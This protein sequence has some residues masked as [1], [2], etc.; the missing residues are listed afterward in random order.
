MSILLTRLLVLS[1]CLVLP[2][3]ADTLSP[4]TNQTLTI[5]FKGAPSGMPVVQAEVAR[6]MEPAGFSIT[7]KDI[8][9]RRAGE[10]YAQLARVDFRGNCDLN[11]DAPS[12]TSKVDGQSLAS[13][14]VSDGQVLP[15][16]VV[17][18]DALRRVMHGTLS[19]AHRALRQNLFGRAAARVLAHELFHMLAQTKTHG[20]RGVSK[21]CFGVADLT[22]EGFNFDSETVAQM[23]PPQPQQLSTWFEEA[24]PADFA[25]R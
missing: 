19:N 8:S 20:A 16:A 14:A 12:T 22:A 13:T 23:R 5:F 24:T 15:F 7:W 2:V 1:A 9:E 11:T 3:M 6:L 18:C 21:S 25:G 4:S 17:Q 10:D